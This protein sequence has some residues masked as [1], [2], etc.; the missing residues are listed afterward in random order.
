M[1]IRPRDGRHAPLAGRL[2]GWSPAEAT[3]RL[4]ATDIVLDWRPE[5]ERGGCA[6][7]L[8]L[9]A[10]NLIVRFCPALR[11]APRS[12]F[13]DE[14]AALLQAIDSSATPFAP[15]GPGALHVH[16][17]GGERATVT[18]S[19]DG[20]TAH[21]SG[22]G[23]VLPPL[24][25]DGNVLGAH[26]AAAFAASQVFV[27]SLAVDPRIAGPSPATSYSLLTYGPAAGP[28]PRL[29]PI[30]LAGPALLAGTGAVG[31]ACADVLVSARVAGDLWVVDCGSIDDVT[32]LN[33]S[34]L[35]I[36]R[37]L[38]E[39]TP[40]VRLAARRAE[41]SELHVIPR[42][43]MIA[44]VVQ[45]IEGG[46]APWPRAV[47]SALDNWD[48]RREVQGLWPDLVLEGTTGD[49]MAQVFRHAHGQP[50]AC[51]RC[52]HEDRSRADYI[53]HMALVTGLAPDRILA[54]LAG[55]DDSALVPDDLARMP[56]GV[57][58]G[59]AAAP[60]RDLCGFL[61]DVERYVGRQGS[62]EVQLSVSFTSYLA[63][64]FLAAELIKA[65]AGVSTPLAG[66]Y[67]ID[68]LADLVPAPPFAQ[69]PSPSCTCVTRAGLVENLR[70]RL[71]SR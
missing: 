25:E 64:T 65:S 49:T 55:H 23:D 18:A 41:G 58:D 39:V 3:G 24:V 70:T 8:V 10:A 51:L 20:W 5:L 7:A 12:P 67:Q 54:A 2:T 21:V 62:E 4:I 15:V 35:A 63:G 43:E 13:A 47:L 60:G 22:E 33:R 38:D 69:R 36:E 71:G 16:L 30:E 6:R 34:V 52:L 42:H 28:T 61:S 59:A 57:R 56:P 40:K 48:A 32:N 31:Q 50:T 17:G 26:A 29:G 11:V 68:P 19:A 9:T 45:A 53:D 27:R 37:D 14:V 44:E 66:R 1:L 46:S